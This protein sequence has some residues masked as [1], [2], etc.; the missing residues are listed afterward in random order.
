MPRKKRV[1][2]SGALESAV[3]PVNPLSF[4]QEW[5]LEMNDVLDMQMPWALSISSWATYQ[6]NGTFINPVHLLG[7]Q[8][9]QN[10]RSLFFYILLLISGASICGNLLIITLVFYS[11]T[12]HSPMYFFLSHLSLLDIIL[13]T[14]TMP[15]MVHTILTNETLV[16]F[17]ACVA[18]FYLFC[19][20]EISES[21]L[22]TV[23]SYDR[24]LAICKPL[25]YTSI[26]SPQ[27]CWKLVISSWILGTIAGLNYMLTISQLQ[28]CGR[29]VIDHF[30]C[31]YSPIIQLA[32]ND[33]AMAQLDLKLTTLIV[34]VIPF[35]LITISYIYIIITIFE[36]PSITGIR[37][38]FS[39]CS[40]H[41]MVVS[42]YYG[43]LLSV[44]LVPH[45]EQ[46]GYISK[47]LSLLYTV[48]TPLINPVIYSL[49]NK[50]L[51]NVVEKLVT[52][53][54]NMS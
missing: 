29:N 5:L 33:T 40:S 19:V 44:Y 21:I 13:V 11:K 38:L 37:K 8:V 39:T 43:S 7:F 4:F 41:L 42:I 35:F 18:Q 52:Q 16:S 54:F 45:G 20:S 6:R 30:F 47:F 46:L 1:V 24:Y 51:K 49:K 22:L 2:D 12:L 36:L 34:G 26:M 53:L 10:L 25:H 32:C 27:A 17:P 50:D 14:D 9:P 23:M 3:W 15:S 48:V 31:D 28:F